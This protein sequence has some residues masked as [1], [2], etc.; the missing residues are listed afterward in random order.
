MGV[1]FSAAPSDAEEAPLVSV[2]QDNA[3]FLLEALG[4]ERDIDGEL[5]MIGSA[6]PTDFMGRVLAAEGLSPEDPG[7]PAI[8]GQ[9][10]RGRTYV[11][12]G[13]GEGYLQRRLGDLRELASYA[14]EHSL[15]VLWS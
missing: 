15:P 1:T 9:G 7:R 11:E 3:E 8:F 6:D 2:S 5:E 4:V 10:P 13:R 12:A 14:T